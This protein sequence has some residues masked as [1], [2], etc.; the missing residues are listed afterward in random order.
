VA[1]A[2]VIQ[3]SIVMIAKEKTV[4]QLINSKMHFIVI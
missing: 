1:V 2:N 4:I 3:I